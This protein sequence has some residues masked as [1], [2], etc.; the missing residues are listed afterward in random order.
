MFQCLRIW[1]WNWEG[2]TP[3]GKTQR[4]ETGRCAAWSNL[5]HFRGANRL[6]HHETRFWQHWRT[7]SLG[8]VTGPIISNGLWL[9]T[10]WL[11]MYSSFMLQLPKHI[12]EKSTKCTEVNIPYMDPMGFFH[13][14]VHIYIYTYIY[15]FYVDSAVSYFS[16]YVD[17]F[18]VMILVSEPWI[19][20]VIWVYH[21]RPSLATSLL[22]CACY[23]TCQSMLFIFSMFFSSVLTSATTQHRCI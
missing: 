18:C 11:L 9:K 23:G 21:F 17:I 1:T 12:P 13:H 22:H 5:L 20:G 15:Q 10:W 14:Y 3:P 16:N 6:G 2:W 19:Q 7:W 8:N 4:T